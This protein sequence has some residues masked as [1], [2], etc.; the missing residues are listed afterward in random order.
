MATSPTRISASVDAL[1]VEP[2][3]FGQML[4]EL[5]KEHTHLL[6]LG[7]KVYALGKTQKLRFPNGQTIGRKELRSLSSQFVK[8]LKGLKKNYVA[9]GKKKKRARRPGTVA[10]FKN[11]ILVSDELRSFFASANL[12]PSDPRD[13]RSAPLASQLMVGQNGV[14][15]QAIMTPV[16][17]IYARLNDMQK[18]P[19]NRQFL[20][21][22]PDMDRFLGA[23]YQRLRDADLVKQREGKLVN[24]RGEALPVFDPRHF[25][26]G[27]IQQIVKD[28]TVPK[29]ALTAD[30]VAALATPEIKA[31]LDQE[32]E[33]VSRANDYYKWQKT[34]SK[35]SFE[36]WRADEQAKKDRRRLG[37]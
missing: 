32:Q 20:T 36:Q 9:R 29:E 6:K 14:T 2:K 3:V 7:S 22:T 37:L 17:S 4:S 12:G 35:K 33:L 27:A 8:K 21:A 19:S 5:A 15:R 23:T 25:R 34:G 13:P 16:F 10:G 31:R 28:N 1:N 11:P 26:Y 24:K 18:D 30:Q